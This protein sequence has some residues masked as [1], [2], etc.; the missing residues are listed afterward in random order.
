MKL[1]EHTLFRIL[2]IGH[3]TSKSGEGLLLK[4]AL[5][6]TNYTTNRKSINPEDL[7][8][9]IHI[10][11]SINKEWVAYS[12]DKRTYDTLKATIRCTISLG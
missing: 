1:D 3:D 2:K 12:G 11:P 7:S 6:K 8:E 9:L 10:N 4:T 5:E